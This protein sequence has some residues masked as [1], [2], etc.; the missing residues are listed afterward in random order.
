MKPLLCLLILIASDIAYARIAKESD[1]ASIVEE[2][3]ADYEVRSNGTYTLVYSSRLR[4]LN[5]AGR[6]ANSVRTIP[7]NAHSSKFELL[8]AATENEGVVQKVKSGGIQIKESGDAKVFD[9][10]KEAVISF[11]AVR[12]GSLLK[13][14]YKIKVSEVP[15]E[16]FYSGGMFLDLEAKRKVRWRVQ[17]EMPIF[18]SATDK[19]GFL[20]IETRKE[21]SKWVVEVENREP[22]MLAVTQEDA[23]FFESGRL[24]KVVVSSQEKWT[25]FAAKIIQE[26]EKEIRRPLPPVF[27]KIKAA[28]ES[29]PPEIRMDTVAGMVAQEIRYFGDWRRRNG[30]HIPRPLADVA[31]TGYGDCKDMSLAIVSIARAMGLKADL[32]WIWR[33]DLATTEADYQLPNDFS[34]NHAIARVEDGGTRWLDSTNAVTLKNQTYLDIA[35]RPALV[36]ASTGV[37]FD[38]T[39]AVQSTGSFS[40]LDMNVKFDRKGTVFF[41]GQGEF[42]GRGAIRSAWSLLNLTRDQ[43]EYDTAR[44]IARNERLVS[45]KV[46]LPSE[47]GRL[48]SQFKFKADVEVGDLGLRTT[49]GVGFPMMRTETIDLLMIETRDRFSDLWLGEPS[50]YEDH[51]RLMGAKIQ[52]NENIG[53]KIEFPVG[54]GEKIAKLS[55]VVKQ[56]KGF[57]L[58]SSRY[59]LLKSVIPN[60]T[61]LTDDYRH[62]Q[63]KVR[64]CFNR[65][66][67]ILSGVT[68]VR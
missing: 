13:L 36:L 59:E 68:G 1:L 54:A 43:L 33:S 20:K 18:V 6:D 49:A 44:W 48:V 64:R 65:S 4:I 66:A 60:S 26:Q 39:P 53:C 25:G 27:E 22:L 14:K 34:F 46:Q 12:V 11:P 51:Y 9:L 17:S 62:F 50:I 67:V 55:R 58:V 57:V 16:G 42:N 61:L 35:N 7:F 63:E 10:T 31:E 23:P 37:W 21:R 40:R 24:P 2:E 8:E 30:G 3:T 29:L 15:V 28:T 41:S 5:E 32:A 56:E 52:G 45:F 38:R 19:Q 47:V